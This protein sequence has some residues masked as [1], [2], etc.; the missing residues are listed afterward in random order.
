[1]KRS[2]VKNVIELWSA[3]S[4]VPTRCTLMPGSPTTS[5]PSTSVNSPRLY[6]RGL[7]IVMA[8]N[9]ATGLC[10]RGLF[11]V[12]QCLQHPIRDIDTRAAVYRFLQNQV[13]F[14]GL[15]DLPDNFVRA[16]QEAGQFL[17]A[18]QI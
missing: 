5:P 3:F 11:A 14:F 16:F 17:I 13:V 18:A 4:S 7:L 1:M 12:G 10:P 8:R 2:F 15:G 6:S 9:Q